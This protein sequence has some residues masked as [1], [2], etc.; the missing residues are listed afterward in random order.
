M[1]PGNDDFKNKMTRKDLSTLKSCQIW[2][3][4]AFFR[5]RKS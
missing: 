2:D 1:L 3:L 4:H 5:Q